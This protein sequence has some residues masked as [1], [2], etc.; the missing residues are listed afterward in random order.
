MIPMLK[1]SARQVPSVRPVLDTP[2]VGFSPQQETD[3][4]GTGFPSAQIPPLVL[5]PPLM[6]RHALARPSLPPF[7]VAI[8]I[9]FVLALLGTGL[10]FVLSN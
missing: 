2:I 9:A 4:T 3:L 5:R 7:P 6:P 8:S 10:Y 1:Y